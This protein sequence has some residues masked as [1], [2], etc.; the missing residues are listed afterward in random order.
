[1]NL[2]EVRGFDVYKIYYSRI[3]E[4]ADALDAINTSAFFQMSCRGL[5]DTTSPADHLLLAQRRDQL[6]ALRPLPAE[7]VADAYRMKHRDTSL[8]K[9]NA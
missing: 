5:D 8:Q 2:V 1:L 6:P 3:I 9:N 4:K 7:A